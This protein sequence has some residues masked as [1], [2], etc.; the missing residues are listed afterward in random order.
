MG[1]GIVPPLGQG[2]RGGTRPGG[3]AFDEQSPQTEIDPVLHRFVPEHFKGLVEE[4]EVFPV[5][6]E[7]GPGSV[8]EVIFATNF[9]VIEGVD[10]VNHSPW[11]DIQA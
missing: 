9:D 5:V 4:W 2:R 8:I 3:A 10:E 6:D 1:V 7:E 11:I